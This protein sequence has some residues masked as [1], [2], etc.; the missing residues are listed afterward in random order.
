ME[1]VA[2]GEHRK[3]TALH[4]GLQLY[5]P[6]V[7]NRRQFL[8]R[9]A[10]N[11]SCAQ[12]CP[13]GAITLTSIDQDFKL[14]FI[15]P[16]IAPC[17]LCQPSPCV[18]ACTTGALSQIPPTKVRMGTAVLDPC[19]C[20]CFIG[21]HCRNCVDACPLAG[22]AIFWDAEIDAPLINMDKCVGC[23]ICISVCPSPERP[24]T[25]FAT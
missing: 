14:P 6:G 4:R 25:I 13:H 18:Q 1:S 20:L 11:G 3:R 16:E 2:A 7:T 8:Q 17:H 22:E 21:V 10:G 19:R 23:G 24:I 5:L 9:C 15:D 12:A